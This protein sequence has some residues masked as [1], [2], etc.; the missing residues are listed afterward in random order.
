MDRAAQTFWGTI[1]FFTI[2]GAYFYLSQPEYDGGPTRWARWKARY[3]VPRDPVMSSVREER[4]DTTPAEPSSSAGS[5][6]PS[7]PQT[8]QAEPEE[9]TKNEPTPNLHN[10]SRSALIALLSVQK[11]DIGAYRFTANQIA[12]FVGGTRKEVLKEIASYRPTQAAPAQIKRPANGW[13]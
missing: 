8:Y 7:L 3:F 2:I 5:V 12:N 4:T 9:P 13:N 1:L 6:H 11:T 10:M